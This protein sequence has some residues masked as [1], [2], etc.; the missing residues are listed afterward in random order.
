M[1]CEK[2]G[3]RSDYLGGWKEVI[4][5]YLFI[6]IMLMKFWVWFYRFVVVVVEI[7]FVKVI[8]LGIIFNFFIFLKSFMVVLFDVYWKYYILGYEF[9]FYISRVSIFKGIMDFC[10]GVSKILNCSKDEVIFI[11]KFICD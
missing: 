9:V 8:L 3:F 10:K 2:Y 5:I 6:C 4:R 11:R 7:N 1:L